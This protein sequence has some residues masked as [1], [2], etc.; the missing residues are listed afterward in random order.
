MSACIIPAGTANPNPSKPPN[1]N[2]SG[3][4]IFSGRALQSVTKVMKNAKPCVINSKAVTN[5]P[6][7]ILRIPGCA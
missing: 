1:K 3:L 4:V 5:S 6:E 7:S 2:F